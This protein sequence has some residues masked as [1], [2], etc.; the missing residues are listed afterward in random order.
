MSEVPL[1]Y[2]MSAS[3][4]ELESIELKRLNHAANLKKEI[5]AMT[6]EYLRVLEVAGVARWLRENRE[7]V[8]AKVGSHLEGVEEIRREDA[9]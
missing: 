6:A 3:D 2:F 8:L 9:A 7:Q 5:D 4:T 1:S